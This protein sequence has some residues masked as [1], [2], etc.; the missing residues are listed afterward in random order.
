MAM[1][2]NNGS[3]KR[4]ESMEIETLKVG[5]SFFVLLNYKQSKI[6]L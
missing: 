5:L 6:L 1:E 2:K 4:R 3:S